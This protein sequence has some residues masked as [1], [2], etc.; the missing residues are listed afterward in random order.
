[1]TDPEFMPR[2]GEPSYWFRTDEA[3]VQVHRRMVEALERLARIWRQL[4]QSTE[5]KPHE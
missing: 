3:E 1:M 2:K 5:S 4:T